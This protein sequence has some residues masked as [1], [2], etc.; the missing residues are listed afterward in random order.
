M[1]QRNKIV[2]L[3]VAVS[4][5][6]AIWLLPNL[7]KAADM[8]YVRVYEDTDLQSLPPSVDRSAYT[9]TTAKV[10]RKKRYKI[11]RI[12]SKEKRSK[13]NAKVFSRIAQFEEMPDS[14]ALETEVKIDSLNQ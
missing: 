5:T 10:E 9:D 1:K 12:R 3:V 7:N 2:V 11:E 4:A 13:L 6:V 14:V 8:A